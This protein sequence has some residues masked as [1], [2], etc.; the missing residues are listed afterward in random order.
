[1]YMHIIHIY[2]EREMLSYI[3]YTQSITCRCETAIRDAG[4][5][6]PPRGPNTQI[7]IYV[8]IYIYIYIYTYMCI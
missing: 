6:V 7:C 3:I 2:R 1:M 5:R 8:Y 4:V